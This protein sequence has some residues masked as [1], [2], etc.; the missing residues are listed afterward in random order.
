MPY[1]SRISSWR[2]LT[3]RPSS[4]RRRYQ[5]T[6]L[7]T[8]L[9]HFNLE[10]FNRDHG[11]VE[12]LL[13]PV[14]GTDTQLV[15]A[16]DLQRRGR[17]LVLRP[18]TYHHRHP[19]LIGPFPIQQCG[20]TAFPHQM[21]QRPHLGPRARQHHAGFA[22]VRPLVA[23]P[24]IDQTGQRLFF[25]VPDMEPP[26]Q[27][28]R[29][30]GRRR[31]A[32]AQ[33]LGR[34]DL[35]RRKYKFSLHVLVVGKNAGAPLLC[36]RIR[37]QPRRLGCLALDMGQDILQVRLLAPYAVHPDTAN[38]IADQPQPRSRLNG[39]LLLGV[40]R[41]DDLRSMALGEPGECD[42]PGG[43]TASPLHQR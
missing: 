24:V 15:P 39:L 35:P 42:A 32:V 21:G 19:V 34:S 8:G 12:Q 18:P 30:N 29:C 3:S 14:C 1:Q 11:A 10:V 38:R 20:E 37:Q 31:I 7:R 25:V 28:M 27:V 5:D 36:H 17:P 33:R 16:S 23:V 2:N 13:L 22:G 40:A 43:S 6:R 26:T 41:E 4:V 9:A